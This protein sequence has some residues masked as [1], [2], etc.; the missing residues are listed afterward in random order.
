MVQI[1]RGLSA[2]VTVKKFA[3]SPCRSKKLIRLC[4]ENDFEAI[5][6]IINEAALVYKGI[7]PEDQ[8]KEPYMPLSELQ[9]EIDAGVTF[10]GYVVEGLLIGVMGIQPVKDVTLIRHAYVRPAFQKK[11]IGGKLL[12][13]L[14]SLSIGP[15]LIGTWADAIWAI[16]FYE[17]HG[18]RLVSPEEKDKLLRRYWS[19]PRRQIE[20]SVVLGDETWFG[21]S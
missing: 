19:I 7:I 3:D 8:W 16:R 6:E 17:K 18:F 15:L 9:E 1:G 2:T 12:S 11:G 4:E 5:Y 14:R 21:T 13:T 20:T 10:W